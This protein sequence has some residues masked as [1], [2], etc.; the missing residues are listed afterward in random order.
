MA[1]LESLGRVNRHEGHLLILSLPVG[2]LVCEQRDLREKIGQ[3]VLLLS[4]FLSCRHKLAHG[5]EQLLYVLGAAHPL[6][7]HV[8]VGFGSDAALANHLLCQFKS[9]EALVLFE[10]SI[11]ESMEFFNLLCRT[12]M[13]I[14]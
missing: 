8:L 14:Q 4:L 5:I 6:G 1:E 3:P 2:V 10:E 12:A 7:G 11:D 13:Y 9:I